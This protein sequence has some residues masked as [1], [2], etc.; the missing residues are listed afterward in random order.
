M[1]ARAMGRT[2]ILP[3]DFLVTFGCNYGSSCSVPT[4][5]HEQIVD[6]KDKSDNFKCPMEY[7]L[8]TEKLLEAGVVYMPNYSSLRTRRVSGAF[9]E[10]YKQRNNVLWV[11]RLPK[12]LP[13]SGAIHL[14]TFAE[15]CEGSWAFPTEKDEVY[16]AH[17]P[18]KGL[19]ET[20]HDASEDVVFFEG[21]PQ[22]FFYG[23]PRPVMFVRVQRS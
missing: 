8:S 19:Y 7:F 14:Y 5:L 18:V 22:E 12:D 20:Y 4:C 23:G 17:R 11:D 15:E 21:A 2:L 9:E 10:L 13:T 6:F 3:Q 16:G 1:L